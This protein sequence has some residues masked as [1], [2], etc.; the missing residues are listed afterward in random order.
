VGCNLAELHT[1]VDFCLARRGA[2]TN[3]FPPLTAALLD[4]L[5]NDLPG[6]KVRRLIA[7]GRLDDAA[8][9]VRLH[10]EIPLVSLAEHFVDAGF[11]DLACSI[12]RSVDAP[13]PYGIVR[14]W[15]AGQGNRTP[16]GRPIAPNGAVR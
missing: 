5:M 8:S 11:D 12:V 1:L 7:R 3:E 16:L 15:L 10:R 9:E 4:R 6:A 14:K 13:D 2:P